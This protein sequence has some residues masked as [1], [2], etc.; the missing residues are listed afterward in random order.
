MIWTHLT[1]NLQFARCACVGY[2]QKQEPHMIEPVMQQIEVD[3]LIKCYDKWNKFDK[4]KAKQ[5]IAEL[6]KPSQQSNVLSLNLESSRSSKMNMT[7]QGFGVS[8]DHS[9]VFLCVIR[10]FDDIKKHLKKSYLDSDLLSVFLSREVKR[11]RK[12]W[13]A[14]KCNLSIGEEQIMK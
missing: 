14:L 8:E 11:S 4:K 6:L 5:N 3:G 9:G 1:G 12:F 13:I 10:L 2:F 7:G